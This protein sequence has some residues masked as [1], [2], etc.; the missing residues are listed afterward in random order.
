M[1]VTNKEIKIA[2]AILSKMTEEQAKDFY[3]NGELPAL[4]LSKLEMEMING[5][6]LLS[7]FRDPRIIE[8][9]PIGPGGYNPFGKGGVWDGPPEGSN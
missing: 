8:C 9:F 4:K 2:K 6:R 7:V 3:E 5:G 1:D